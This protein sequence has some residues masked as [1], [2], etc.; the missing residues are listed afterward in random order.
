MYPYAYTI[1][2]TH[3]QIT[4]RKNFDETSNALRDAFTAS[5]ISINFSSES[6]VDSRAIYL[7]EENLFKLSKIYFQLKKTPSN[8]VRN[9]FSSL[10]IIVDANAC[11]QVRGNN[12]LRT[13]P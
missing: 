9:V 1:V 8:I 4:S 2:G 10:Y 3:T 7:V 11:V 12:R 6:V 5:K 13:K